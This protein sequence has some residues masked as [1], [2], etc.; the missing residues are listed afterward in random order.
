MSKF[1]TLPIRIMGSEQLRTRKIWQDYSGLNAAAAEHGF[2]K[3]MEKAFEGTSFRIRSKPQEFNNIYRDVEL[4]PEVL[5]EI[6]NPP[7]GINKHGISPDYAIDN[8][9]TNKTL[10][11]EVKRQ[12]GWVEGGKRS[13]GR[14]NAHE[15]SSKY[16][17]P[18]LMK[19]M[20]S[21]GIIDEKSLPFWTVFQGDISRDPCRVREITLWY[22][23]YEDHFFF[24]RDTNNAIP[25]LT[26]FIDRLSR[27]LD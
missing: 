23:I 16:F 19:I 22:D 13:D 4:K 21:R 9:E 10:Y 1:Q 14:G 6:H 3:V 24:W 25:L 27:L 11:V 5:A 7:G 18:G 8:T 2:F 20:R 17:T 12:D 26:H 15:R